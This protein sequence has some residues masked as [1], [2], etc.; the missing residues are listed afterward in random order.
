MTVN[1]AFEP[2]NNDE[3]T[4]ETVEANDDRRR[5]SQKSAPEEKLDTYFADERIQI[6]ESRVSLH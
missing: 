4:A 1:E 2:D 6:P 5:T 3:R